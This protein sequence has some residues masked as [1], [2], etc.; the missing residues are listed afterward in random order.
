M[1][2]VTL[3]GLR[4]ASW[5][6]SAPVL[7]ELFTHLSGLLLES[8]VPHLSHF[9]LLPAA[10]N[11]GLCTQKISNACLFASGKG[12]KN[13]GESKAGISKEPSGSAFTSPEQWAKN[14]FL[15]LSVLERRLPLSPH[16]VLTQNLR[17]QCSNQ[18]P[19]P[20]QA[21]H[22]HTDCWWKVGAGRGGQ[23]HHRSL[24]SEKSLGA[25]PAQRLPA[26]QPVTWSKLVRLEGPEVSA[27]SH[28]PPGAAWCLAEEPRLQAPRKQILLLGRPYAGAAAAVLKWF[29]DLPLIFHCVVFAPIYN[30]E[31]C[32]VLNFKDILQQIEGR[33]RSKKKKEE[34]MTEYQVWG[35]SDFFK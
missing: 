10:D 18:G 16:F 29:S 21:Y 2:L 5:H 9:Q 19:L 4:P 25:T 3:P 22:F 12:K 27:G 28:P 8:K 23:P 17:N 35:I 7:H 31:L 15:F 33:V 6:T 24:T 20:P 26:G 30:L 32:P 34:M 14:A 11:K 1:S 13:K